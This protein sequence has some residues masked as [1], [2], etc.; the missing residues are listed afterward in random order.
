MSKVL[1]SLISDRRLFEKSNISRVSSF[2]YL[3]KNTKQNFYLIYVATIIYKII[4]F[5]LNPC[6]LP[7]SHY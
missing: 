5:S 6:N 1:N 2:H 3:I 7:N 4:Q